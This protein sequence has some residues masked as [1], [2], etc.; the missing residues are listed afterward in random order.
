MRAIRQF[1]YFGSSIFHSIALFF[2]FMG[3]LSYTIKEVLFGRLS[4]SWYNLFTAIYRSGAKLVIPMAIISSL[5]GI[6]LVF[7]IYQTLSPFNLQ[8]QV[9]LIAQN[10]L[11]YDI[12]PFLICLILSIQQGL[13]LVTTEIRGKEKTSQDVVLLYVLPLMLATSFSALFLYAYAF[14]TVLISIYFCFRYLLKTDIHEYIFQLTNAITS[15]G[16]FYSIFKTFIYCNIVSLI[17][18]YYYYEVAEG[19]L[20]LRKAMSRIMTRS[21]VCL[22]VASVYL[23]F[24]DYQG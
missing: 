22:A 2:R 10:I 17:V 15:L 24:L 20:S 5:L 16:I 9:L 8:Q 1:Q 4:I 23:K 21:F 6:S 11:F 13:N 12:L 18:G 3:H 14:N 7:N 19:Y